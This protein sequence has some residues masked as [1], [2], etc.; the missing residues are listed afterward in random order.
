MFNRIGENRLVINMLSLVLTGTCCESVRRLVRT[1]SQH[2]ADGLTA[3]CE[4]VHTGLRTGPHQTVGDQSL[5][6]HEINGKDEQAESYEMVPV[7]RL[8][9]EEY[10]GEHR[11]DY[12]RDHLLYHLEL[13]QRERS[14]IA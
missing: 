4:W 14:A 12:E 10:G 7:Q 3:W 11:E 8:A 2:G 1:H 9:L 5:H 6:E 13:H